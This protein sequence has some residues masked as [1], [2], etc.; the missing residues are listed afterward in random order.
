M[1]RVVVADHHF[2]FGTS[3]IGCVNVGAKAFATRARNAIALLH[4]WPSRDVRIHYACRRGDLVY[5]FMVCE[6]R[7]YVGDNAV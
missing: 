4:R 1:S 5:Y 3:R 6:I 7:A 2:S